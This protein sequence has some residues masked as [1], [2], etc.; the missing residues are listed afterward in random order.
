MKV[1]LEILADKQVQRKDLK[2]GSF[3]RIGRNDKSHWVIQDE[4][5]SGAHCEFNLRYNRLV[6]TDLNSKNGTYLNGIRIEKADLYVGDKLRIGDTTFVIQKDL[7]DEDALKIL[8]FEGDQKERIARKFRLYFTSARLQ[9]KSL[10]NGDSLV[11]NNNRPKPL[12]VK[13][14]PQIRTR[15]SKE[16]IKSVHRLEAMVSVLIDCLALMAMIYLPMVITRIAPSSQKTLF[17]IALELVMV[18]LFL[19]FNFAL[20]KFTFGEQVSG[21]KD[22]CLAQITPGASKVSRRRPDVC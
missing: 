3:L 20:G 14:P 11:N 12:T 22:I 19:V 5:M 13:K 9:N 10:F 16:D 17:F 7:M 2:P 18:S 8:T 4:K 15:L 1:T 6:V 21:I